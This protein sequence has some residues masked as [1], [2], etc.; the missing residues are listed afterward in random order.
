M[1]ELLNK[2]IVQAHFIIGFYGLYSLYGVYEQQ[3]I[4]EEAI[5]S[6][7][8]NIQAQADIA[9]KKINE[10]Q[11]FKKKTEEYKVRVEEVARNIE[12]VQKQLPPET[13]DTQILS[14]FTNEMNSLNIKTPDFNPGKEEV[15]AYYIA[16]DYTMKARGTYL[17]FMIF[18]ERIGNAD[19]I[20]NVKKLRLVTE[21]EES[22]GRFQVIVA[23][24][25]IQAYRYNPE[26]KVDRGFEQIEN[27]FPVK[28]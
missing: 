13:N 28:P 26:F 5:T 17:Q 2:L 24:T 25:V 1:K 16:K 10:I 9:Q 3:A 12:S 19:R 18:F 21:N 8:P 27:K 4:K 22:K 14:Y 6:Q 15:G 20:Y 11:E 23:E 7:F